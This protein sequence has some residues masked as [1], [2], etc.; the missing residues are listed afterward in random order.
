MQD[1]RKHALLRIEELAKVIAAERGVRQVLDAA[2]QVTGQAGAYQVEGLGARL[3][4]RIDGDFFTVLG[5][6]LFPLL[7]HLRESGA[8]PW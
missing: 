1:V 7:A 2:L 4:E 5:L 3:F 6:P 8:L